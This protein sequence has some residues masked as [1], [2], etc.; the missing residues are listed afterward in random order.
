MANSGPDTN[1]SS[2]FI[3]F[4]ETPHLDGKHVVFGYVR[5]GWDV[6]KAIESYG[7]D[8]VSIASPLCHDPSRSLVPPLGLAGCLHCHL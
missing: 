4:E 2:F 6:V 5:S 3:C 1:G 8:S 7:S